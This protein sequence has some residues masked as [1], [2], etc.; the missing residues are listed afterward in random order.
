MKRRE[1]IA[2]MG[3]AAAWPAISLA[4]QRMPV[5]GFLHSLRD[6]PARQF[7]VPFR[8]GLGEVGYVEGR[9][10]A[11]EYRFADGQYDRLPALAAD[12]VRR[13]VAVIVTGGGV[14]S[15]V[16]ATAATATIPIVFTSGLDPVQL[17]LV[18][19]LNRPGGNVTG[20]S[21]FAVELGSKRLELLREIVGQFTII[22]LL[23]NPKNPNAPTNM[24]GFKAAAGAIGQQLIAVAAST[25]R[26]VDAAFATVLQQ[27]AGAL[28]VASDP[29][30]V[31]QRDQLVALAARHELPTIYELREFAVAGGLISYGTKILEVYRQ[32]G[33]YAGRILNG[34][35]PGDLPVMQPARLEMVINLK[36]AKALGLTVPE[37]LL[38]TAD[39]VIQ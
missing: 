16:A 21:Y 25:E 34:E 31:S 39:E 15:A 30:F 33:I 17:G 2:G 22:A 18:P 10:V 5:I 4:Q 12:L 11:I 9:N 1:F 23:V 35:K 38:A 28:I 32:G 36:A 19:N 24:R 13:Q 29:F 14:P 26:E 37:T 6:E 20:V 7:T 27:H 8:Q 3:S